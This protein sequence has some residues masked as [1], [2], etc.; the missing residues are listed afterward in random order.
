MIQSPKDWLAS[1]NNSTSAPSVKF[2]HIQSPSDWLKAQPAEQPKQGL[3]SKAWGLAKT[4]GKAI[5]QGVGEGF[6]R[7]G[8]TAIG[9]VEEALSI[10]GDLVGNKKFADERHQNYLNLQKNGMDIP[11]IGNVKPMNTPREAIA[12]GFDV[13]SNFVGAGGAS[14]VVKQG[15]KGFVKEGIK[16]GAKTGFYS[17]LSM[18]A[19]K[20]LQQDNPTLGGVAMDTVKGG[21]YGT[22]AGGVL[23]GILGAAASKFKKPVVKPKVTAAMDV[24]KNDVPKV[25]PALTPQEKHANYSASQ[26]YEPYTPQSQLPTIQ[27]GAKEKSNLPTIAMDAPVKAPTPPKGMTY[28]P[29]KPPAQPPVQIQQASI[30]TQPINNIPTGSRVNKTTTS[31]LTPVEGTGDIKVRGLANSLQDKLQKSLGALPEYNV[32]G[33]EGQ[34]KNVAEITA[35]DLPRAKRIALGQEAPPAGT[36][37]EAFYVAMSEL[38][39]N[40]PALALALGK[41][42]ALIG[43]ATTMGQRIQLLSNLNPD[44]SVNVI[45]DLQKSF[46]LAATKKVPNGN[47]KVA[48]N[49]VA[50]EIKDSIT[51]SIPKKE[52]WNS[53]ISSI[54]C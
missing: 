12:V 29:I 4:G 11:I 43:D 37:P 33:N 35:S 14:T 40:D 10:G 6:G 7:L 42:S 27:M 54:T 9:G 1:Q 31:R 44:S 19:G 16:T 47:I 22:A 8:A 49:Q 20:S 3:L 32:V 48:K 5:V 21:I 13:G 24:V 36:H 52:D 53:F 30:Q 38:A 23:G 39:K 28:E 45:R 15:L 25:P 2:K 50:R 46:D 51:R 18:G 26:G 17:G 34:F 41:E